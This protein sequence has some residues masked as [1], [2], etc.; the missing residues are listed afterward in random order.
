M[1]LDQRSEQNQ[2]KRQE[3]REF[4]ELIKELRKENKG[5]RAQLNEPHDQAYA[6]NNSDSE[7]KQEVLTLKGEIK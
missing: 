6:Q 3:I 2:A 4:T 7:S 5:L 1:E